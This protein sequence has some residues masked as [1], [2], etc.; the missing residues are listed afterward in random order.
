MATEKIR[1]APELEE[2]TAGEK[3]RIALGADHAGF[4]VKDAIKKHLQAGDYEV[5]DVG[6]WSEAPVDYPDFAVQVA[7]RVAEG[8]ADLGIL[9]CGTGIG[10]SIAANKVGGIRAAL[11]H[12]PEVARL[13]RQHNDANVL[14]L[15]ARG[16]TSEQ[17]IAIVE[18]F[19]AAKFEGGRHQRRIAKMTELD[20]ERKYNG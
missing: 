8:H 1:T 5:D 3:L 11:A 6:T 19:L 14:T 15:G 18:S 2:N 12:D 10:M 17:A 7:T 9:T 16:A 20:Q 4:R 13:A